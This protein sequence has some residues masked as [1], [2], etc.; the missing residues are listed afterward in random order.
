MV[1]ESSSPSTSVAESVTVTAV[2]SSV[3]TFSSCATGASFTGLMVMSTLALA[4]SC[5]SDMD[6]A[7]WSLPL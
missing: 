1:Y 6:T 4:A 2:S 5:P 3:V 7:I